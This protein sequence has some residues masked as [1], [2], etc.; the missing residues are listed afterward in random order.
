MITL[1]SP[2]QLAS[3][4][5]PQLAQWYNSCVQ[6]IMATQQIDLLAASKKMS[7]LYPDICQALDNL[8]P[9][10]DNVTPIPNATPPPIASEDNINAL[11]LCRDCSPEEFS[12]AWKAAG[13][14]APAGDPER[15]LTSLVMATAR[16]RNISIDAA[17]QIVASRHPNLSRMAD[18]QKVTAA[19]Q[20]T[21]PETGKGFQRKPAPASPDQ[22]LFRKIGGISSGVTAMA[23][24]GDRRGLALENDDAALAHPGLLDYAR[25]LGWSF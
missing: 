23:N 20:S 11:G 14:K 2:Q 4:T 25:S 9:M 13:N 8:P 3:M 5:G 15:V 1:P 6:D 24:S 16:S 7:A 10:A 19:L 12:A 17:K 22:N 18:T 21:L